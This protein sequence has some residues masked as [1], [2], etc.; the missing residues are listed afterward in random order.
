[1]NT[2]KKQYRL[3]LLLGAVAIG[4]I[5][6]FAGCEEDPP[7]SL[8]NPV[9]SGGPPPTIVSVAPSDSALAGVTTMVITGTNFSTTPGDNLVFFNASQATVLQAT[10]T[11][12]TVRAP[13]LIKDTI[14]LKVSVLG[15][16]LFSNV[17]QYKL[18]AAVSDFGVGPTP[19]EPLGIACDTSGNI[20]VSML[21]GGVGIGDKRFTPSGGRSDYSPPFSTAVNKWT[22]LK[23]G[24]GSYMYAAAARNA[25]FRIPPGGG[26]SAPWASVA[27]VGITSVY[28][29]DF[30]QNKNIWGGGDNAAIVRV[31]PDR[32]VTAFPFVGDVR[33]VRVF[34][35]HLYVSART[36]TV[37]KIWR[38]PLMT[39][40]SLGAAEEYFDFT[41]T[42]GSGVGA[43]AIT[44]SSL[45]DGGTMFVGTDG[46][47]GSIVIVNPDGSS[48]RFYP[49]LFTARS[50]L[51]AYG[52]GQ[53]LFV[54]RTGSSNAEKKI[55]RALTQKNGAPYYGR[56]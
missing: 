53:E 33:S 18:T 9:R 19:E 39:G 31:K 1:M 46:S 2:E 25:I 51:F 24:P 8:Y 47:A 5:A 38:F 27:S 23:V 37:W 3:P 56:E 55:I 26:A 45:A 54:S 36:D 28:D 30:D 52:K 41:A 13:V 48:E 42:Y 14:S 21:S 17:I 29:F 6:F 34:N 16:E 7:P 44:F 40:D 10:T 35:G 22:A 4:V 12:L 32:S 50:L 11:Q 15:S 49:G 20:Y 43:Y